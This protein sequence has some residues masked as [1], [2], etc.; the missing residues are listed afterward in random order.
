MLARTMQLLRTKIVFNTLFYYFCRLKISMREN[1]S[2]MLMMFKLCPQL[3]NRYCKLKSVINVIMF[4]ARKLSLSCLH[5]EG[6]V[7]IFF[8]T[9]SIYKYNCVQLV[10]Q[11]S[12]IIAQINYASLHLLGKRW[13]KLS[14]A[15][16][17]VIL[18]VTF[19]IIFSP[20]SRTE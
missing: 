20:A 11:E 12:C 19:L 14:T 8:L 5:L 1:L 10:G 3:K 7:N 16:T 13:H 17:L 15:F 18:W 2:S 9:L 4:S 6:P